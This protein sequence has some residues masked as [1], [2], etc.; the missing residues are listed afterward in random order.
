MPTF[1]YSAK[2]L[3]GAA[4]S[5]ALE[6]ASRRAAL[7]KLSAKRL[8]PV[9]VKEAGV[10]EKNESKGFSLSKLLSQ[11]LG[12]GPSEKSLNRKITLP[13]LQ[14]LREMLSCGIQAGDAVRMMSQ[15]LNDPR[16]KM[17]ANM[18][19]DDLRQGRSLSEAFYKAPRV[20]DE[21]VV[22]LIEAGEAT[23]SLNVVLKRVVDSME[24]SNAIKSKLV[25]ALAYPV[26]LIMVSIGL[27]ML[28][29][30]MLLPQIQGLLDSLGGDLP[31]ST[32]VLVMF[33]DLLLYYGWIGAL[34][35]VAGI[36][37]LVSWRKTKNGRMSFDRSILRLPLIGSF[38]RD[39]QVLRLAQVQALLL[40]NGITMVQALSMTERSLTNMSMRHSFSEARVKVVEGATLSSALK[41][42]GYF[43][44]M[45]LDIFTVGENTGNVVPGLKQ[46]ARQYSERIDRLVKAFLGILSVAVLIFVCSFV[47]LIA[48]GIVS[49]VFQLSSTL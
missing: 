42:T 26:F 16:Q 44:E 34:G 8:K 48:F 2:D 32:K 17:L 41:S 49:A 39:T 31:T 24:E 14:S 35:L 10:K 22:S 9:S 6:A 36:V 21:S 25:A 1:N 5:G 40:E 13:F 27:V 4:V 46:L 7:Q 12:G 3:K 20:F 38:L 28:F 33:S 23:G 45:A 30:F 37:F 15:R 19:W 43:D 11:D 47:A 29:L 18:L